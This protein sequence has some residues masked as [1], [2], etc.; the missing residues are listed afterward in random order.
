MIICK[1]Q[2]IIYGLILLPHL[3]FAQ[4]SNLSPDPFDAL[5][6]PTENAASA[7]GPAPGNAPADGG[8]S[9]I[10]EYLSLSE[11]IA[12]FG[13]FADGGSDSNWYIGFNNAWIVKLP[14]AAHGDYQRAFIGAKIGRAK[15]LPNK[16]RPWERNVVAGKVYMAISQKP[17]FSA[18]QSFFL[19]ETKDI[20]I[21]QDEKINLPGTGHSEWFWAEVPLNHVSFEFPNYLIIWSPTPDFRGA[22]QSPILAAADA[23][24]GESGV[25]HRAWNNHTLT[26]VPPRRETGT[27]QVPIINL[28][29]AL[30]I[31]LTPP[32]GGGVA[33]SDFSM[34]PVSDEMLFRFSAEGKNVELA[35]IEMSQDKL[36]WRRI[37]PYAR[38]PPYFFALKR[39]LVPVRGAYFRG[40]ARDILS[41]EGHCKEI[42]VP[43]ETAQ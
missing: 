26:G 41:V 43:G 6:S 36:E 38:R 21:E 13:R 32:P 19:A 11:N 4:F 25:E 9:D 18:E 14:P 27:L 37:S 33:V 39:R 1:S 35:W 3:A 34:K 23:A 2:A 5:D 20:P 42:F 40:K 30:A 29:P 16:K 31:K 24:P 17:A 12:A 8:Y 7:T 22:E 15:T 10:P 28:K